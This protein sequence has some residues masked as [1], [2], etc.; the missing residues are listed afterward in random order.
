RAGHQL[1]VDRVLGHRALGQLALQVG[2]ERVHRF[3]L[4]VRVLIQYSARSMARMNTTSRRVLMWRMSRSS[5]ARRDG[6]PVIWGCR[7]R[8][9]HRPKRYRPSNSADHTAKAWSGVA[10]GAWSLSIGRYTK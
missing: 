5:T 1:D 10:G 2:P 9:K 8:M 4:Q 7:V 3:L 6:R